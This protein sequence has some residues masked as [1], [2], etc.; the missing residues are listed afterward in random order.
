MDDPVLRKRFPKYALRDRKHRRWD[1][2]GYHENLVVAY[3]GA[4]VLSL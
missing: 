3:C 4:G 1:S 2:G